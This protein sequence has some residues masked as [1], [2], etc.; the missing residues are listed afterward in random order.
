MLS[1]AVNKFLLCITHSDTM[2]QSSLEKNYFDLSKEHSFDSFNVAFAFLDVLTLEPLH[3][4]EKFA[5]LKV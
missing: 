3:D 4:I 1:F 2:H 5:N